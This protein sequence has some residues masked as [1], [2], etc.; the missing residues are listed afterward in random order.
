ML[1]G[2]EGYGKNDQRTK[3]IDEIFDIYK[4]NKKSLS[5][6]FLTPSSYNFSQRLTNEI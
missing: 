4:K 3:V 2:F 6:T 5:I 1:A